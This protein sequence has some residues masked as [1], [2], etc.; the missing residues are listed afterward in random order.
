MRFCGSALAMILLAGSTA[1]GADWPCFLG[2]NR[3]G[4]SPEAGLL[5]EWPAEGPLPLIVFVTAYDQYAVRAFDHAAVDYVLKPVEPER[6]AAT[7]RRLQAALGARSKTTNNLP[8]E[9]LTALSA[10]RSAAPPAPRL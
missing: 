1:R 6:L 8:D 7:C 5:A 2:P 9:L 3:N 10:L 4:S